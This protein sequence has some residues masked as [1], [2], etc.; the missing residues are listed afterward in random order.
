VTWSIFILGSLKL[1]IFSLVCVDIIIP[2][3]NGTSRV[4]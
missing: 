3:T 1:R 4:K 2:L